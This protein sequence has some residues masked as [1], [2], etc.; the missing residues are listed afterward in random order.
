MSSQHSA[1]VSKIIRG[2]DDLEQIA[3]TGPSGG[4]ANDHAERHVPAWVTVHGHRTLDEAG[5]S[6]K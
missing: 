5:N 3:V 2:D 4:A 1:G 6:G